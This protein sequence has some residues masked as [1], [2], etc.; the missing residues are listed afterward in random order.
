M[1]IRTRYLNSLK[2]FIDKPLIKAIT[3][4]RRSGKSTLLKQIV[5][6]LKKKGIKS[7]QIIFINKELF[8]FD[9]IRAYSDLHRYVT[10]K[11]VS[12]YKVNYLFVDEAQEIEQWE[13][14]INSLLA[15]KRYDVY[16]TGSNA[17]LLSSE[18]A[19]LLSGRYVEFPMFT[20]TFKEFSELYAEKHPK[21][22]DIF[23]V[24]LKYGG[25]PGLHSMEWEENVLYQYLQAIYN[26]IVLKDLV[27][28]YQV[29]DVAMLSHILTFLADNCG[30]ITSAKS[31]SDFVKSQ[32][33]KVSTDTVQNYIHF[34]LNAMLIQQ[35]R[36]YDING[37]RILET[38]EK[39]FMNDLGLRYVMIGYTPAL[40]S[41]QLENAVLLEMLARGYKVTIGKNQQKEIDFIV[42]KGNDK[43]YI[44]VCS[45]LSD[46]KVIDREYGAYS[47]VN[48]HFPKYV[49]SLD[50]GFETDRNGIKWM[51]IKDFLIEK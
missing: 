18:L 6:G 4:I 29:R 38:H 43:I 40:I 31:I 44:Q 28:R 3:G 1:I 10:S 33:R 50:S 2:P 35:V 47:G 9:F 13:K 39:Y 7:E 24:F 30:N 5:D 41:G 16:I 49:L 32:N 22:T 21:E 48:D 37:K 11:T 36:R 23:P 8:E 34:A 19:T 46:G 26:T 42:E 25:F 15:E 12:K 20:L 51:N 14:A 27:M 45:S 17:S